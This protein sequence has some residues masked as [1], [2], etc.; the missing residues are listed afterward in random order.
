MDPAHAKIMVT[1]IRDLVVISSSG[2]PYSSQSYKL[3]SLTLRNPA[4]VNGVSAPFSEEASEEGGILLSNNDIIE[5]GGR[6]FYFRLGTH[7]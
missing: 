5:M 7:P 2:L 3:I 4:T 1:S 6:K